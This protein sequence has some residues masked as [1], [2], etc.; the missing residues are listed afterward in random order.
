[1]V[2]VLT[3]LMSN[4]FEENFSNIGDVFER[5]M[6]KFLFVA[7]QAF[8][9]RPV[10]ELV[11]FIVGPLA[12]VGAAAQEILKRN[13]T[14]KFSSVAL[15]IAGADNDHVGLW[16][17][18]GVAHAWVEISPPGL[19]SADVVLHIP[20]VITIPVQ[21]KDLSN[22]FDH[23]GV[24]SALSTMLVKSKQ[25]RD[26]DPSKE[27]SSRRGGHNYAQALQAVDCAFSDSPSAA[28]DCLPGPATGNSD[29]SPEKEAP[30][31][32]QK[33]QKL[34]APVIPVLYMSRAQLLKNTETETSAEQLSRE[35]PTTQDSKKKNKKQHKLSWDHLNAIGPHCIMAEGIGEHSLDTPYRVFDGPTPKPTTERH[36]DIVLNDKRLHSARRSIMLF[37]FR[38]KAPTDVVGLAVVGAAPGPTEMGNYSS[39]QC[40][41][42]SENLR[43]H[44]ALSED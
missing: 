43:G 38:Q 18:A 33:L 35:T 8:H 32:G 29:A 3:T 16:S 28:A 39:G 11:D 27:Y 6:A 31:F 17:N 4:A 22:P 36:Q 14:V 19:P 41:V 26:P 2:V 23:R 25:W 12:F 37:E 24:A 13:T 20:D 21:C 44:F 15:R 7:A 9:G 42:F 30:D 1:M 40:I 34:G 5:D 10:S